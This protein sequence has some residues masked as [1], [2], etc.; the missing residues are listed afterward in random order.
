MGK[1]G[2]FVGQ[3]LGSYLLKI[4][5]GAQ[6]EIPGARSLLGGAAR[7][8]NSISKRTVTLSD[9]LIGCFPFTRASLLHGGLGRSIWCLRGDA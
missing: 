7:Q 2:S 1:R 8:K 5:I 4:V 9:N 6:R 3:E